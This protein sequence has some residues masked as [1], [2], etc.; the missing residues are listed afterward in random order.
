[1]SILYVNNLLTR[2]GLFGCKGKEINRNYHFF[3]KKNIQEYQNSITKCE[4]KTNLYGD[5]PLIDA[6]FRP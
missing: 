1:M 2:E 3:G 6:L 4:A 5:N